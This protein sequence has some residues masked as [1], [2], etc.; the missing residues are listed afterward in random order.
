[1]DRPTL[2]IRT[3]DGRTLKF[4]LKDHLRAKE[5]FKLREQPKFQDA[6]SG[7]TLQDKGLQYS[8]RRPEKF[9]EVFF[10]AYVVG[11][12]RGERFKGG[13]KVICIA[14]DV[15]ISLLVHEEEKAGRF[16]IVRTGKQKY[17]P[18]LK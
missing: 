2:V 15:T 4:D 16:S 1:M 9:D 18:L 7:I 14:G 10:D 12:N 5:W 3:S 13:T 6:I 8:L 17:N 11:P